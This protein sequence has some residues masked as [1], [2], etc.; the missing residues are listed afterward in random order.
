MNKIQ[1]HH[2]AQRIASGDSNAFGE[3][4]NQYIARIYRFILF[5]VK[6]HEEAED[7]SAEVFL[8]AWQYLYQQQRIAQSVGALLYRMAKNLVIDHYRQRAHQDVSLDTGILVDAVDRQQ[9]RLFQQIESTV[10]LGDIAAVVSQLKDEYKDVI[11]LRYVEELAIAEI[12]EIVGKSRGAI[13]V[14]LFRALHIIR[15]QIHDQRQAKSTP[16][17]EPS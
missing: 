13:R 2:L 9:Q 10:E 15:S 12:A 1:Q 6:T 16:H 14:I 8:R 3:L 11:L 5:K 4:Y 7:L 17:H